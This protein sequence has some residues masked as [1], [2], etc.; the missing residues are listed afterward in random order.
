MEA[1][2]LPERFQVMEGILYEV[3][4]AHSEQGGVQ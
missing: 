1:G 2:T 4:I 3:Y